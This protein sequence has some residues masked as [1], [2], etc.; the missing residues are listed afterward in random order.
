MSNYET[1]SSLEIKVAETNTV[2]LGLPL[3]YLM[4][5]AGRSVA[6]VVEE[7]LGGSVLGKHVIVFAGKGGNAGDGFVA[8]RH[9]AS[10]GA[11]VTV[12]LYYPPESVSHNDAKFNLDLISRL[13]SI[14]VS[15][16]KD[17]CERG[18]LQGDV[19]IDAL[20]GIGFSGK[21]LRNPVK[22]AVEQ[23]NEG[24]ALLKVAI[25]AP[26]G[27]NSDTGEAAEPAAMADVTVTMQ[28]MKPGLMKAAKY[29]GEVIVAK[30]GIPREAML[31]AGPGD[32]KHRIPSKPIH[33]HKGMGG[34]IAIIGG[35]E[36]YT[37][38]PALSG[39][40]A[41][42]TGA[43]LAFIY[44][45][46]KSSSI[47]AGFDP[48][49][50]IRSCPKDHLD[51]ECVEAYGKEWSK[52]TAIV[53]GPGLGLHPETVQAVGDIIELALEKSIPVVLDADGLKALA[54]L[55]VK[56]SDK[57]ILTPHRGEASLLLGRNIGEGLD[58]WIKASIDIA[59]KYGSIVLLKAPM[60]VIASPDG[61]YRL[62]RVH[63]E[64]M[65]VGGTGD[66]L[67]G[68]IATLVS[69]GVDPFNAA[70]TAAYINGRAGVMAVGLYGERIMAK[71]LVHLI[72]EVFR[73]ACMKY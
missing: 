23:F 16:V 62:N 55:G 21:K 8:A 40:A 7:K 19:F 64:A 37:G 35:S 10:R 45:G 32:V 27:V 3:I 51:K 14:R 26:T 30:I 57:F 61:R 11:K 63:H 2:F 60:D 25:D 68:I 70:A 9:L 54:K 6:D 52:A 29:T 72:P 48:D 53:L 67:T 36:L 59:S 44:T 56:A 39:L 71:D 33:A 58:D 69:R 47:I 15:I 38:A 46:N 4:E 43:D 17:Y 13:D 20:L 5:N 1:L 18:D 28:Y 73:E 22:A 65:S 34:R 50:I 24:K 42:R 12:L 49:L 31:Y 66:V 41:L